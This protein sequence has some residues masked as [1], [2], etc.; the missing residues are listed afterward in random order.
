MVNAELAMTREK[1]MQSGDNER[2]RQKA[3]ELWEK[4]GRPEGRHE[5]HWRQASGDHDA[6][7]SPNPVG[8]N[9]TLPPD[10]DTS[11]V[12]DAE[13]A[14]TSAASPA[15]AGGKPAKKAKGESAKKPAKKKS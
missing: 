12:A 4:E 1:G 13:V 2:I 9:A 15:D 8:V 3:Y 6:L 5:D 10:P 11:A 7:T 14:A